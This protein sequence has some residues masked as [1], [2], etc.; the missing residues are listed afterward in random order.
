MDIK[1]HPFQSIVAE[2]LLIPLYM[3]A[4]E[5]RR[6]EDAILRDPM[7]ERL[8]ESID[9]DYSALDRAPLSEVGCVVR[10]WYFDCAV[11]R[12]I[13][14][15]GGNAVMVNVGCGLDTRYQRLADDRATYY[16]LDLPEVMDLRRRLVPE[17]KND[18][19]ISA[20]LLD[21]D[22]M[23]MLCGRHPDSR[24]IFVAEGVLMYFYPKQVR[25][26]L[27]ELASRFAGGEVW[28]D[29]CGSIM[30]KR[31]VKPDSLRHHEAQIRSG[32]TDGH[33]VERLV[34]SLHL[35]KQANYMKFFRHRWGFFYGQ[36]LGRITRLCYKFSSLLGYEIRG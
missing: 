7:A 14:A 4:K 28:F 24:F 23:D 35:I 5:S 29:V 2:T 3:R 1:K 31:G 27:Q 22:W 9:Y 20:S 17:P 36:V 12:F 25:G 26:F 6:G 33:E 10:G 19:Y 8:A 15:C 13:D 18:R 32:I 16:E 11:R 30:S 21:T 34:P